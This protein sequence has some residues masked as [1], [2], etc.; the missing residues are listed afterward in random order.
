MTAGKK[1]FKDFKD[2]ILD[3]LTGDGAADPEQAPSTGQGLLESR[4]DAV[5]DALHGE[6]KEAVSV[7]SDKQ[8]K[9]VN[10]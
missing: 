9:T 10:E 6:Y 7:A 1:E 3:W 2:Y 8:M 5:L 4:V